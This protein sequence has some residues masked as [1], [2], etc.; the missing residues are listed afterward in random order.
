MKKQRMP[1]GWTEKEIRALAKRHD[2]MSEDDIVAEIDSGLIRE[3]QTVMV[4]PT[5]LV[6]EITR[7]IEKKCRLEKRRSSYVE[8]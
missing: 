6:P 2:K 1:S 7:L 3:D 4:V 5:D 8:I